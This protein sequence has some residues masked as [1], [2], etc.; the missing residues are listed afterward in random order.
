M[1]GKKNKQRKSQ[2]NLKQWVNVTLTRPQME[3][4]Q[5]NME[6]GAPHHGDHAAVVAAP[7]V[8]SDMASFSKDLRDFKRDLQ[9]SISELK[10]DLRKDMTDLKRDINSKLTEVGEK[11]ESQGRSIAEA[12]QRISDVET[13]GTVTKEVILKLLKQQ[14]KLQEKVTDLSSRSRRNNIRIFSVAEDSEAHSE[15][16]IKFVENLITTQL[17]INVP[18]QIQR[19]HRSLAKKPAP[20]DRPRSIIVNF[21]Q[22]EVKEA[23]LGLAW[24]N[25]VEVNSKPCYF[26]HDFPE[27]VMAKRRSYGEIKKVLKQS[28]IGY[29]TPFTKIRIKWSTGEKTYEDARAAAREMNARG[30]QVTVPAED[31]DGDMEGIIRRAFPWQQ[32]ANGGVR[33]ET[34]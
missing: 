2:R 3:T 6:D 34:V 16:M 10:D 1:S 31:P 12:E 25:K 27:E 15:S 30:L 29:K 7:S 24:K 5:E 17:A 23:V 9:T 22:F 32:V 21:L 18:L 19:A 11:L 14:R 26:D 8:S 4:T 20:G 33:G 28:G 13:S